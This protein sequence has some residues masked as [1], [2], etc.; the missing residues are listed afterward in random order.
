VETSD[1]PGFDS[2]LTALDPHNPKHYWFA[3][4]Y[5]DVCQ[6]SLHFRPS[7]PY[8]T[9][10]R[11]SL[12]GIVRDCPY[13]QDP[14]VLYTVNAVYAAALGIDKAIQEICGDFYDGLCE[15]FF[16]SEVWREKV[17]DETRKAEFVDA[18][19]QVFRFSR[20]KES[21]RGFHIYTLIKLGSKSVAYSNVSCKSTAHVIKF[22][23][24]FSST[25]RQLQFIP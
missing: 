8:K 4:Y 17:F 24:K 2:Y 5:E 13:R 12:G 1:L 18:T 7:S 11:V 20:E 22:T 9:Q 25:D 19:N 3:A 6:C 16:H 15:E 21:T 23:C 10:C 14:Y